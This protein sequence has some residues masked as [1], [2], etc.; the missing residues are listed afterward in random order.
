MLPSIDY[1]RKTEVE[2]HQIGGARLLGSL[3]L[4][5]AIVF[6]F[7]L[8]HVHAMHPGILLILRGLFLVAIYG[9]LRWFVRRNTSKVSVQNGYIRHIS[10]AGKVLVEVDLRKVESYKFGMSLDGYWLRLA[11]KSER[12]N[13]G[14]LGPDPFTRARARREISRAMSVY[15]SP[16]VERPNDAANV[17]LRYAQSKDF[18]PPAVVM[19]PGVVYRYRSPK[20]LDEIARGLFFRIAKAKNFH[21]AAIPF[22]FFV[23][24]MLSHSSRQNEFFYIFLFILLAVTGMAVV[25]DR[26]PRLSEA[27]HDRFELVPEGLRIERRGKVWI[28]TDPRPAVG[29]DGAFSIL[30]APIVRFGKGKDAYY[31]DPRFIE[32]DK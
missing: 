26:I 21:P 31:F 24:L 25:S 5:L 29:N 19:Q 7:I 12:Y 9:H 13:I 16:N 15:L 14:H 4:E 1:P 18:M 6:R 10:P 32:P 23:M 22:A 8:P 3:I 20:D 27:L 11:T 30:D 2:I 28:V 17:L